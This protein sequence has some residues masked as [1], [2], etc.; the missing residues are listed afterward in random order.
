M[1]HEEYWE[2]DICRISATT[3]FGH[4]FGK[5]DLGRQPMLMSKIVVLYLVSCSEKGKARLLPHTSKRIIICK[6]VNEDAELVSSFVLSA[7]KHTVASVGSS[8]CGAKFP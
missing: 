7:Y 3:K 1:S 6:H 4:S 2:G 5:F 8:T